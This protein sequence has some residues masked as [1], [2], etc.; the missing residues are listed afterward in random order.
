V[1]NAWTT[2][3][4]G[5][6]YWRV[7]LAWRIAS[8]YRTALLGEAGGS[9][10]R[11]GV[12]VYRRTTSAKGVVAEFQISGQNERGNALTVRW[13]APESLYYGGKMEVKGGSEGL[14]TRFD[15]RMADTGWLKN[16][17]NRVAGGRP[18]TENFFATVAFLMAFTEAEKLVF[19]TVS[20]PVHSGVGLERNGSAPRTFRDVDNFD[21]FAREPGIGSKG[22]GGQAKAG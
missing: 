8:G 4:C 22:K 2:S 10:E 7:R 3:G 14:R 9:K 5:L 18:F 17:P 16:D 21:R 11:N 19:E 13:T 1:E 6:F 12:F 15:R 20:A